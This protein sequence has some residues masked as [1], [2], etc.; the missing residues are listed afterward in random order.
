MNFIAIDFETATS[1]RNSACAVGIVTVENGKI[2]EEFHTLIKPPNNE[3]NW[4]NVQVHGITS[5][6][7][8][9]AHSFAAIYPEIKKRL[10]GKTIVAHN[11]SFDRS[12]L[13]RTMEDHHLDYE[14][15]NISDRWEC[16]MKL[17]KANDKYPSGKLNDCCRVDN[18]ALIHHE[19]LSDAR[20]CAALYL[21]R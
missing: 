12:V 9:N 21:I 7:T 5:N 3:Y 8:R 16:T 14:E 6:D 11:E 2:V 1:F 17:C 13:K 4:R 20:A 15:L 10:Q 18:I 19:A